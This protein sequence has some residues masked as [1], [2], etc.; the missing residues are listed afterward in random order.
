[1]CFYSGSLLAS[2]FFDTTKATEQPAGRCNRL[3]INIGP[4]S[5]TCSRELVGALDV[6]SY[7]SSPQD[8]DEPSSLAEHQG[9]I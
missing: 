3:F 1:M 7:H 9:G 6:F 4:A 8:D 2:S 5:S